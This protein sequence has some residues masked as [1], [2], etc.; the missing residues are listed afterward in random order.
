MRSIGLLSTLVTLLLIVSNVSAQEKPVSKE[1][2]SADYVKV[3]SKL[4]KP[5]ELLGG[6]IQ[7][8]IDQ[9]S[10]GVHVALPDNRK[11]DPLIFGTPKMPR[12]YGG[13]PI[14]AGVPLKMRN[15]ENG[16]YTTVKE[17][18]PFGDKYMTMK[19]GKLTLSALDVT[20]TDAA[21]TNDKVMMDASWQDD[22]GNTYEV[23]CCDAMASHGIDYPTFGG[24]AT[25]MVLHG[26]SGIGTPLM[27]SEYTYFAFWGMGKILKNGKVLAAPRLIHG[28][29]TEYVRKQNYELGFDKDVTPEKRHFHLITPPVI[30]DMKNFSFS[31]SPVDTG[32]KLPNGKELPFWHV[33]FDNLEIKSSRK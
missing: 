9:K 27:P 28:M 1:A 17:K 16:K 12:N 19:N 29:L 33:M 32:F 2:E 11:L 13:T 22:Q 10:G 23:K 21:T 7:V 3:H 14:V 8:D 30:P 24:V 26:F 31:G 5:Y 15:Q 20:A 4:D 25:N 6:P 18:T